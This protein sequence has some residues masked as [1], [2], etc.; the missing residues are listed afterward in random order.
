MDI[1]LNISK[2]YCRSLF[3]ELTEEQY[4]VS[5]CMLS[6][7]QLMMCMHTSWPILKTAVTDVMGNE[8]NSVMHNM[9]ITYARGL[10]TS[11]RTEERRKVIQK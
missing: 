7:L 10:V 4:A 9:A 3:R 5:P 1:A 6:C 11:H 2:L 8:G